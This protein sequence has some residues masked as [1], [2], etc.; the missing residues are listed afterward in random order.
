MLPEFPTPRRWLHDTPGSLL[1]A[2]Y[3]SLHHRPAMGRCWKLDDHRPAFENAIPDLNG[4]GLNHIAANGAW[5]VQGLARWTARSLPTDVT[6]R[7][8]DDGSSLRLTRSA[9]T[10]HLP[11]AL[12]LGYPVQ[13][14][15][16][17]LR[18][19]PSQPD[20]LATGQ[21]APT[22]VAY[23]LA[24]PRINSLGACAVTDPP[25]TSHLPQSTGR[26]L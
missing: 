1:F 12:A 21:L 8:Q 4:V 15:L 25:P 24:I 17:W 10:L 2:T 13:S 23:S 14:R 6:T 20:A 5:P 9:L 22:R 19:I 16:A 11:S 7:T 18:A 26:P 3:S